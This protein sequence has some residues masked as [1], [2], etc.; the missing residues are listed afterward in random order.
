MG[1]SLAAQNT[2]IEQF[3]KDYLEEV[4]DLVF[5]DY[6][7]N[8]SCK[9]NIMQIIMFYEDALDRCYKEMRRLYHT[10][11]RHTF[12]QRVENCLTLTKHI[13]VFLTLRDP[14][15][16]T[17]FIAEKVWCDAMEAIMEKTRVVSA[18]AEAY[19]A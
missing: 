7:V 14:E 10:P 2:V 13:K 15:D 6:Y 3:V 17:V 12:K 11:D 4:K 18:H 8:A 16:D 9:A 1:Y 19:T 5:R